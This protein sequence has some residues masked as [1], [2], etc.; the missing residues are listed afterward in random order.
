MLCNVCCGVC[1]M[2]DVCGVC[3]VLV[4]WC[5]G[6]LVCWCVGD[7]Y[8]MHADVCVC[9]S[10]AFVEADSF[11]TLIERQEETIRELNTLYGH[12]CLPHSQ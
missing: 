4:C 2:C 10:V 5:V 9:V 6:V 7:V 11:Q 8:V 1:V 12:L 3:G